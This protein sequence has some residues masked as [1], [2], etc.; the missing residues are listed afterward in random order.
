[1]DGLAEWVSNFYELV[2]PVNHHRRDPRAAGHGRGRSE[3]GGHLSLPCTS[4]SS[5]TEAPE[6]QAGEPGGP[7]T[8]VRSERGRVRATL[9]ESEGPVWGYMGGV[10]R[11]GVVQALDRFGARVLLALLRQPRCSCFYSHSRGARVRPVPWGIRAAEGAPIFL[12]DSA[13]NL[14]SLVGP[15]FQSESP[16]AGKSGRRWTSGSG[17]SPRGTAWRASEAPTRPRGLVR[18]GA[19]RW[20]GSAL[21]SPRGGASGP[22]ASARR[23]RA[24][25]PC[26]RV[27]AGA[28]RSA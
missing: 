25:W 16:K 27:P 15:K 21:R 22:R 2:G 20:R 28:R 19:P 26:R 23:P 10:G 5:A 7:C 17:A 12:S 3:E 14:W 8:S 13:F 24:P 4:L 6:A 1:M 11:R 9:P 18:A